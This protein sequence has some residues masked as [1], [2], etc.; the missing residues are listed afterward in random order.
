ME[1]VKK[2]IIVIWGM[3]VDE[4]AARMES[5]A[6]EHGLEIV[7]MMANVENI[8]E[9]LR[10]YIE[11]NEIKA[12]LVN[13]MD[14]MPMEAYALERL[15]GFG[16]EH[17]VSFHDESRGYMRLALAWD[18]DRDNQVV[19]EETGIGML[20]DMIEQEKKDG[21]GMQRRLRHYIGAF[22]TE[23]KDQKGSKIIECP[24]EDEA[25]E[26]IREES[27]GTENAAEAVQEENAADSTGEENAD[28]ED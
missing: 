14:E 15:I 4:T 27:A 28:G 20:P 16:L 10:N 26:M 18:G 5:Y 11:C 2:C 25:V 12:V 19:P 22:G 17:D 9:R 1:E 21:T 23:V 3:L 13:D 6:L 8:E 24:T 7:E